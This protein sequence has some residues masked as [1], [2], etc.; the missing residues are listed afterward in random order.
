[1]PQIKNLVTGVITTVSQNPVWSPPGGP[2]GLWVCG[3]QNF[4]DATGTNYAVISVTYAKLP[5]VAFYLAFKPAERIAIKGSTD[6]LVQEFW[7][8][9]ELASA[10]GVPIDPNLVS[11]QWGLAYLGTT[12]PPILADG[13]VAQI[14]QGLAQ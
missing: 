1:M 12:T 5:P 6:P 13:R 10:A 7:Q 14:C 11:I 2:Q 9:F 3:D 4:T 8:T